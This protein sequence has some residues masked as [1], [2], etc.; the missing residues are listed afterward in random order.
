[1][2]K[3]KSFMKKFAAVLALLSFS[4]QSFPEYGEAAQQVKGELRA[5][6]KGEVAIDDADDLTSPNKRTN[7]L[8]LV[9]ATAAMSFTPKSAIPVVAMGGYDY[10]V[11]TET[12]DW[13]L[14]KSVY[15]YGFDD[16]TKL[17]EQST[18][19]MGA[20][21]TAWSGEN[22]P[23]ERN[24][25][26][27]DI[28]KGNNYVKSGKTVEEDM[29]ANKDKYYFPFA[30]GP[31]AR[32]LRHAYSS[33]TRELE[34]HFI[35]AIEPYDTY[36]GLRSP[37]VNPYKANVNYEIPLNTTT[38][39]NYEGTSKY[40][41]DYRYNQLASGASYP[42]A[43]VF[44][45]PKYWQNGWSGANPPGESDL[46]PNDSRMYQ[47]KL[48]LW[49]LLQNENLFKGIR[50]G[51]AT[52]FLNPVNMRPNLPQV[53]VS[54][55]L[56]S[57]VNGSKGD[58]ARM[59]LVSIFRVPPYGNNIHTQ[60]VFDVTKGKEPIKAWTY[61]TFYASG[62]KPPTFSWQLKTQQY[63]NGIL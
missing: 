29:E 15:G 49:R 18:F 50:F 35:G 62:T 13:A 59:D 61:H 53:P 20:L 17:M 32:D 60:G 57:H 55:N 41:R 34:T 36:A 51:L 27:R 43:L 38:W 37:A 24:L 3:K 12:A 14:T 22:L 39:I 5:P 47:T 23:K 26:G 2:R 45:D 4:L 42:Y 44:K 31:R 56:P 28:D 11:E 63:V 6:L 58:G 1:M 52:T 10:G 7:V 30:E 48:V 19:G 9:E 33:Q 21:P 40:S 16:I 25:Y 46:V 54:S 8:F